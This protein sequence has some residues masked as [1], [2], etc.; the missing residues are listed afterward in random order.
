MFLDFF[1]IGWAMFGALAVF[2]LYFLHKRLNDSNG[3]QVLFSAFI[4]LFGFF[5]LPTRIYGRY[6]FPVFSVL[7][8][9]M[10]FLGGA[11]PIFGVLTLTYFSNQASI[12]TILNSNSTVNIPNWSLI[13][14]VMTSVNLAAFLYMLMLMIRGLKT[15]DQP[16]SI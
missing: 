11:R 14:Y 15:G 5:M 10:P 9:M 13:V 12:L 16:T 4:L 2:T 1:M 3:V 8:L 6:L 7:A